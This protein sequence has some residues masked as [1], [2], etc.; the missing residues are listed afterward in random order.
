[1]RRW[2][3]RS[4]SGSP[5]LEWAEMLSISPLLLKILWLRGLKTPDEMDRFLCA[6]RRDLA[7]PE[8]WPQIP[9]SA[10]V[11]VR[12]IAQGHKMAVWGDYDVDGITAT[13]LVLDVLEEHGISAEHH[14]PD[15]FGEGYGLNM[16]GVE[17]LASAGVKTLLTV[18]CGICDFECIARARELGMTVIVSDHHL[19][20]AQLPPA[21][22]ICDPRVPADKKWPCSN[23]AGVG[24]AFFLMAAVNSRLGSISGSR[25]KMDRVLDLAALGTLADVMP[26]EGQNRILA[27]GGLNEMARP[28]RPG[29]AALKAI[30]KINPAAELSSSQVVFRLTPRLNAAGRMRHADLAL[31]LLR[32]RDH[33]EAGRL[34]GE[35]DA[36][37]TE[38]KELQNH[39]H[40][41]AASQAQEL[42]KKKGYV[43][44][45]LFG[46]GWHPGVI[47]NVATR[48]VDE[49]YRP[50]IVFC[51]D[52]EHL[53][54]SGRSVCE[55]DLHAG[56][57]TVRDK[58]LGFG[59]H[60]QAAGA[61]LESG[62]LEEFR[63]AFDC[64]VQNALGDSPVL[65]TT[66]LDCELGFAQA[67]NLDFLQELEKLEPFG[68]GNE[69]PVFLSPPL[70]V[71]ER[72]LLGNSGKHVRLALQ[73]MQSGI[74]L[75]AKA[76]HRAREFPASLVG[77]TLRMAYA[78]RLDEF[79]GNVNVD[80]DIK[81]WREERP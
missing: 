49:F 64:A 31:S 33:Q 44:L 24:V 2:Q 32:A 75:N 23:L 18:D 8:Q 28:R 20:K 71:K 12:E 70:L 56:L 69:E 11:L 45:V 10:D 7:S 30:S 41:E 46:S 79:N 3:F 53:K 73:D 4:V 59:G 57:S 80:V 27:R 72:R 48:I 22:A 26:L 67:G 13:A 63:E 9:Q 21:T 54:G 76:W 40:E 60:R 66:V 78:L 16:A 19:P 50:T 14:L 5:A 58:L 35:L 17:K 52:G 81:D 15:R 37:N 77:K 43:S 6:R 25:F 36:C 1:M 47:G 38:R 61:R 68:P 29:L 55:F 34:A 39:I 42:L 62:R 51:S 74:T 65:P